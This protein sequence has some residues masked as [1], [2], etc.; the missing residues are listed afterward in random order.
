VTLWN[1]LIVGVPVGSVHVQ[2]RYVR[3]QG[4]QMYPCQIEIER[5]TRKISNLVW[6]QNRSQT[7]NSDAHQSSNQRAKITR[8]KQA[9]TKEQSSPQHQVTCISIH[10]NKNNLQL[11][12]IH[13]ISHHDA[14]G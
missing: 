11:N 6:G 7:Q 2:Y 14:F 9:K 4:A 13:S 12:H 10:K 8:T 5:E 3:V 1:S